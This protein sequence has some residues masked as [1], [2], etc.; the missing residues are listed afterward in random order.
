MQMTDA[1][2]SHS[3]RHQ[4]GMGSVTLV[5]HSRWL[6]LGWTPKVAFKMAC[7]V[8]TLRS[9]PNSGQVQGSLM[10]FV[11]PWWTITSSRPVSW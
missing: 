9:D 6:C 7:L 8:H 2:D 11:P 5:S 1:D 10:W 4:A 3:G